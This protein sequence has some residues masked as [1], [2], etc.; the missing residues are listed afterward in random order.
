MQLARAAASV[1]RQLVRPRAASA[2][3]LPALSLRGMS[4]TTGVAPG[5]K[6]KVVLLYR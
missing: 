4:A 3:S 6:G 1:G 2:L 5:S